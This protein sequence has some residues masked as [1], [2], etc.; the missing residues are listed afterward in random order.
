MNSTIVRYAFPQAI[1]LTVLIL[2]VGCREEEAP[3]R[4]WGD[5]RSKAD[6]LAQGAEY[7]RAILV[8]QNAIELA[9]ID[10]DTHPVELVWLLD[11]LCDFL[12]KSGRGEESLP[13]QERALAKM[14]EIEGPDSLKLFPRHNELASRQMLAPDFAKSE[15]HFRRAI[16][17]AE[18]NVG[19]EAPILIDLMSRYADCLMSQKK[20]AEAE[21]LL[22]RVRALAEAHPGVPGL[23]DA[24]NSLLAHLQESQ[25]RGAEAEQTLLRQVANVESESDTRPGVREYWLGELARFYMDQN[26]SSQAAGIYQRLIELK[27]PRLGPEHPEIKELQAT[28]KEMPSVAVTPA[29]PPLPP[30]SSPIPPEFSS[31]AIAAPDGPPPLPAGSGTPPD[32]PGAPP[33]LPPMPSSQSSEPPNLP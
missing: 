23:E 31:D 30:S 14:I 27:Q 28:L 32:S 16:A 24:A 17:L 2:F 33:A 18:A 7:D 20:D 11:D 12:E 1:L 26:Q 29:E 8:M 9:E 6:E 10:P 13:H 5:L 25:G 19:T 21:S 4:V 22:L 3:Q 15:E